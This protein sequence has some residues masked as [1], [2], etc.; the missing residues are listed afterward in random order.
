MAV[1]VDQFIS[2]DNLLEDNHL[3]FE[4]ILSHN[5]DEQKN[6]YFKICIAASKKL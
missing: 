2:S 4:W 3:L 1:Q 5:D 6:N